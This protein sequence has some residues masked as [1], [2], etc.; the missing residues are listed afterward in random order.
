MMDRCSREYCELM[1]AVLVG[2]ELAPAWWN[3]ANLAFEGFS[4]SV[5]FEKNPRRV[6]NYLTASLEGEW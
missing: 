1:V 5:M 4:P 6:Y 3:R 2:P